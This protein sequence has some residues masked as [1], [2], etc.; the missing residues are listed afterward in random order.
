MAEDELTYYDN[1]IYQSSASQPFGQ[2][3]NRIFAGALKATFE[4]GVGLEDNT[5][6]VVR[7]DFSD[8]QGKT[9]SHEI[10][11]SIGKVGKYGQESVWQR[12]GTFPDERVIRLT[13]T[14]KV[15]ANLIKL[16]AT[17]TG[18]SNG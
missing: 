4:S 10:P 14:S 16:G 9:F 8:D 7:L 15:R 5:N 18:A 11:R 13:I 2:N 6:P 12:Q 3:G 1:L 17:P